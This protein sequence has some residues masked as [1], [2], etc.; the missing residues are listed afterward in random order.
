[1]NKQTIRQAFYR[2]IPVLAG[3]VVLGIGFGILM[4]N[5]GYGVLWTASMSLLIYAGSIESIPILRI[6]V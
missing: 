4:R 3:Y 1:M 5:A 2:S 6:P